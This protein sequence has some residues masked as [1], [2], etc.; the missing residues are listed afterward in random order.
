MSVS[1]A[2]AGRMFSARTRNAVLTFHIAVS[3][4]LLGDS[5]G[6]LAV[7]IRAARADDPATV[8]EMMRVL[9]MFAIVFGIPL[10]FAALISGLLLGFGT[11]WG[12]VRYPWVIAK[13]TLIV[14]V[15]AVGGAV[16]G[17]ALTTML[18]GGMGESP[19]L[20]AAAAYDVVALA[21]ATGLSVFKPGRR[22]R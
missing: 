17:P 20:V 10:S 1:V 21:V 14:S 8:M 13:L 22:L 15:I 9:N 18:A 2:P 11:K 12:V 3:V 19:R 6:F 7:A 4:G 16:I 5:A